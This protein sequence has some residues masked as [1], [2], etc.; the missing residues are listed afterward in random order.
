MTLRYRASVQQIRSSDD[1]FDAT[2]FETDHPFCVML[3]AAGR[4][5]NPSRHAAL[6]EHMA[7]LG[8]TI[9]APHFD[10]L[11]TPIPSAAELDR[12]LQRLEAATDFIAKPVLP[13]IGL[14]H[15]LGCVSLLSLAGARAETLAGEPI[16]PRR[17][18]TFARLALLAPP[19]DFFR[20]PGALNKVDSAICIWAGAKDQIA[21]PTQA[22]F[23]K[24]AVAEHVPVTIVVDE[25]AG[26]FSYMDELPPQATDPHPDR[27]AFLSALA[28]AVGDFVQG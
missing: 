1:V 18:W 13:L 9:I 6:L 27:P 7:G 20:R 2:V 28:D 4:G 24:A 17:T 5:G 16:I 25:A 11:T 3:F 23:L 22:L 21:P 14:G 10:F 19:T 15:S 8:C 12:R 26:H